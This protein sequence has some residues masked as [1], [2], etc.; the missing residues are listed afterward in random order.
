MVDIV[1][2]EGCGGD[3]EDGVGEDVWV[4]VVGV[5]EYRGERIVKGVGDVVV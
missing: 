4:F 2:G 5:G 1:E 3:C